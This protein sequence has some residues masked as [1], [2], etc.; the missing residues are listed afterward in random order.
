MR[1]HIS[2][3]LHSHDSA[4]R[5]KCFKMNMVPAKN[6]QGKRNLKYYLSGKYKRLRCKTENLK[7]YSNF[8]DTLEIMVKSIME[9][10]TDESYT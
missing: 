1:T 8:E 6:I 7:I 4:I 2:N 3:V 9:N 5:N 10:D